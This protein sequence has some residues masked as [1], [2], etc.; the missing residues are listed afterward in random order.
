MPRNQVLHRDP[1]SYVFDQQGEVYRTIDASCFSTFDY[2]HKCRLYD[3]L[4]IAHLQ[5]G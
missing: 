3:K 4:T 1:A 5:A 2:L